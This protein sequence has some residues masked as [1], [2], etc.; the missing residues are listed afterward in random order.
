VA[1][2]YKGKGVLIHLLVEASGKPIAVS[3][4]PANG[5]ERKEVEKLLHERIAELSNRNLRSRSMT[6]LEA[7]RGYDCQW[8]RQKLLGLNIFPLIPWRKCGKATEE[9]PSSKA[10]QA[11]FQITSR[12]WQVERALSWIKRKCRR[13]M[14]RWERKQLVWIA[15]MKLSIIDYWIENLMG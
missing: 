10:I 3:S 14:I 2:G 13:I 5:D 8:L 12:R 4:T 9:K 1:H 11:F 6:I 7:D 15:F